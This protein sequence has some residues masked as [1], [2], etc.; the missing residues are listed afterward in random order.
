[1]MFMG[2]YGA[3]YGHVM[4]CPKG[5]ANSQPRFCFNVLGVLQGGILVVAAEL[6]AEK[7]EL[8]LWMLAILDVV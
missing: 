6:S 5:D 3:V 7:R 8:Q 1:M 4:P 2:F